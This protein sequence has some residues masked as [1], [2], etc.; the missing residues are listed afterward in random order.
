MTNLGLVMA[1]AL[2]CLSFRCG[3]YSEARNKLSHPSCLPGRSTKAPHVS[4]QDWHTDGCHDA[5]WCTACPSS[6]DTWRAPPPSTTGRWRRWAAVPIRGC[7]R[8]GRCGHST[9]CCSPVGPCCTQ[10]PCSHR[11]T[12]AGPPPRTPWPGRRRP[13]TARC[14]RTR[15][16]TCW[17]HWGVPPMQTS[18]LLL[19]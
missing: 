8:W 2:M 9:R 19:P 17:P 14:G 6:H 15:W 18:S 12:L 10:S 4:F 1:E 7:G 13:W 16:S 3:M 11:P 5:R